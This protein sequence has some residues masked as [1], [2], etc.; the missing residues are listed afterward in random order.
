MLGHLRDVLCS[1][2][3]VLVC[4]VLTVCCPEEEEEEEED[5]MCHIDMHSSIHLHFIQMRPFVQIAQ[6]SVKTAQ[7]RS[8][9]QRFPHS[10]VLI[11]SFSWHVIRYTSPL[12]IMMELLL[13]LHHEHAGF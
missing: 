10:A 5:R 13:H 12:S 8:E 3:A 7:L 2:A 9:H 1:A 11:L 4:L 6:A